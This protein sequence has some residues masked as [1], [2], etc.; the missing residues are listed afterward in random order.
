MLI[1]SHNC[2][3]IAHLAEKETFQNI[4]LQLFSSTYSTLSN[5]KA[6]CYKTWK[7]LLMWILRNKLYLILDHNQANIAHLAQKRAFLEFS[8]S[9][10]YQ[11][12]H[13]KACNILDHNRDKIVYL[14]QKIIFMQTSVKWLLCT[15]CPLSWCKT[16]KKSLKWVLRYKL[17]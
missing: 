6:W 10:F 15:Y 14:L 5:L 1:F 16:W 4:L 11:F 13:I 12:I 8:V 7:Y 17:A 9:N 3:Q 2:A